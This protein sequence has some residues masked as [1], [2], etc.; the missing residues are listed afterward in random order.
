MRIRDWS[1]DVCSSDLWSLDTRAADAARARGGRWKW[2]AYL[3]DHRLWVVGIGVLALFAT[4]FSFSLLPMT[5]QPSID[6]DTSRVAIQLAPEATLEQTE[7]VADEVTDLMKR[8]SLVESAL[9]RIDVGPAT[10]RSEEHTSEL[11]SIM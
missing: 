11:P 1:S 10:V 9:S 2:L 7:A 8:D 6:S 4:I 5:F 3:K